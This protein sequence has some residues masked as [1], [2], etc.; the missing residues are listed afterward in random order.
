M[1]EIRMNSDNSRYA[2]RMLAGS[3]VVEDSRGIHQLELSAVHLSKGRIFIEGEIDM[4]TADRFAGAMLHLSDEQRPVS[5][6]INST[7]GMVDAGLMMYD[8]IQSYGGEINMFCTGLA[9]SMAAV[10]LAGGQK[11]RRFI[12]PHSKVMIHEPLIAG[13]MG[14]SAS[15]I[16][17]TAK[18][19]LDVKR[20]VNGIL[21]EHTGKSLT[22]INKATST[23][24][25]MDARQAVAFGICDEIRS[26]F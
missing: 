22:E 10:L 5:I 18:N 8:V 6:F 13:G 23:D 3:T 17:R 4:S 20:L 7:G 15:T 9:A 14:G 12:L 24:N 21:A 25:F 1:D 16:E 2:D 26:I 11:G 19:I